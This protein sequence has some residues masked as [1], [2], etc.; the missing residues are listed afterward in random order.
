[1]KDYLN[2]SGIDANEPFR[3]NDQPPGF[4]G[5]RPGSG[6]TP[7]EEAAAARQH[8]LDGYIEGYNRACGEENP[9]PL[10]GRPDG[11]LQES[12]RRAIEAIVM[13][14]YALKISRHILL[15]PGEVVYVSFDNEAQAERMTREVQVVVKQVRSDLKMAE[16]EG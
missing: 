1:M 13:R 15:H 6:P 12:N 5:A 9:K 14:A 10:K 4:D 7:R 3:R 16:V 11:S 2:T 8:Y